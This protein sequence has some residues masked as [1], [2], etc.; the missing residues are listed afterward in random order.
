MEDIST[1]I[2]EN[3]LEYAFSFFVIGSLKKQKIESMWLFIS[4]YPS[5]RPDNYR[6]TLYLLIIYLPQGLFAT[7]KN[8][9]THNESRSKLYN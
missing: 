8:A 1:I 2:W 5:P 9:V 4:Y 3:S 6:N 7:M